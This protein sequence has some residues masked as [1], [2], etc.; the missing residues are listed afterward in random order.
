MLARQPCSTRA[1]S[2]LP[3]RRQEGAAVTSLLSR[4]SFG[5]ASLSRA[6]VS[7]DLLLFGKLEYGTMR[8]VMHAFSCVVGAERCAPAAKG[9]SSP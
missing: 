7:H 8:R 6:R 3:T 4:L 9:H 1:T 2:R 5:A